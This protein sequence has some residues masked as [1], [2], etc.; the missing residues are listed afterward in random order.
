MRVTGILMQVTGIDKHVGRWMRKV[1]TMLLMD[2][3]CAL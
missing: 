3:S 1:Y 2:D